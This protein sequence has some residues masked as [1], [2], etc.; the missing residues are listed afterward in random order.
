MIDVEWET[1]C[2]KRIHKLCCTI[3][4]RKG[5]NIAKAQEIMGDYADADGILNHLLELKDAMVHD[6]KYEFTFQG[7]VR[8]FSQ[9]K[10]DAEQEGIILD[11]EVKL[12]SYTIRQAAEISA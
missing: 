10:E 7:L 3:Y 8:F 6:G 1:E 5:V 9:I 4:H 2:K 11:N 12:A